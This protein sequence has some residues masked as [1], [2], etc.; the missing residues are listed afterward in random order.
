MTFQSTRWCGNKK[1]K[2]KII[3]VSQLSIGIILHCGAAGDSQ[4]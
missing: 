4:P 2:K 3:E 1:F